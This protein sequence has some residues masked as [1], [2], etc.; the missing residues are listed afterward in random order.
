M[1]CK[2]HFFYFYHGYIFFLTVPV[3]VLELTSVVCGF[4][5]RFL[6]RL[7]SSGSSGSGSRADLF[8]LPVLGPILE[9][10]RIFA[11]VLGPILQFCSR[12]KF[13]G[14]FL[15]QIFTIALDVWVLVYTSVILP[16]QC[17]VVR[18]ST[19]H[20]IAPWVCAMTAL[21]FILTL[22]AE[23]SFTFKLKQQT[24]NNKIT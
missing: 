15:V 17:E 4:R 23:Y 22:S 7:S 21:F 10:T 2:K 24:L 11:L 3:P 16:K 20:S 6:N 19:H 18:I 8:H 13:S 5:V 9:L 12:F 1:N 14:L